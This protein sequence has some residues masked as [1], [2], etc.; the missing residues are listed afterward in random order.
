MSFASCTFMEREREWVSHQPAM[1]QTFR[2]ILCRLDANNQVER[3][4]KLFSKGHNHENWKFSRKINEDLIFK[5]EAMKPDMLSE[6][7]AENH[8]GYQT[9]KKPLTSLTFFRLRIQLT[10]L[11]LMSYERRVFFFRYA[12]VVASIV[13][14]H[15]V[16]WSW[17]QQNCFLIELWQLCWSYAN[18]SN[19]ISV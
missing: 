16:S 13:L 14:L 11:I 18:Q 15:Y 8:L 9:F 10:I 19:A 5:H 1:D 7:W 4:I 2:S 12:H 3:N 6:F 17:I